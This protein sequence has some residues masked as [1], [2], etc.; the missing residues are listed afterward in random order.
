MSNTA[1][2]TRA[3]DAVI[4]L[5]PAPS[6]RGVDVL[7]VTE[8][9]FFLLAARKVVALP[10]RIWHAT[11][12]TQAADL[13]LSTPCAVALLDT[14]LI[15]EIPA[16]IARLRSQFPDLAFVVAGEA[17]AQATVAP[18]IDSGDVQSFVIKQYTGR[19]L[20]ASLQAGIDRHLDL[21]ATVTLP[22]VRS[23]WKRSPVLIGIGAGVLAAFALAV[24][25]VWLMT[26]GEKAPSATVAAN[27]LPP[28]VSA[29]K[30]SQQS[31]AVE[32]ELQ[33]AREAFEAGRYLSPGKNDDALDHYR[34]ALA[35]DPANAEAKDGL[36]R[37]TE[38]M[39]ARTE[40][41]LVEGNARQATDNLK[42][43]KA[44]EPANPRISF[45]ETQI[46]REATRT[47]TAQQ[48]AQRVEELNRRL[49]EL[50]KART[51]A[52][53]AA[54]PAPSKPAPTQQQSNAAEADRL[55]ALGYERLTQGKLIQPAEDSAQY[56]LTKLKQLQPNHPSLE[57][58]MTT[59]REQLL[60]DSEA[61]LNKV[62]PSLAHDLLDGAR[63]VGAEGKRV[64][65]LA[66]TI[67]R[68]SLQL[69]LLTNPQAL[70]PSMIVRKVE[71]NYPARARRES[72]E[73]YVDLRFTASKQ[74]EVKDVVVVGAKP[75]GY[76]EE[77]AVRAL[78]RWKLEPRKI[79]GEAYEQL[80][81]LRL[82]FKLD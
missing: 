81:S 58:A 55:L 45:L 68:A 11:S 26:G 73:G 59:L 37:I 56:Y 3:P 2:K 78:K 34:A 49:D 31:L 40:L 19:R 64:D 52:P 4:S 8:D 22:P 7:A 38:I 67:S 15:R 72:V 66:A 63:A 69:Q 53:A 41:A 14:D 35:I 44:I 18:L 1:P 24:A 27:T 10:N 5:A 20:A 16:T 30:A 65:Q 74:G 60:N 6:G 36:S 70:Q 47:A 9:D 57:P 23:G 54:A 77:E 28:A 33:M 61:A 71:P 25:A 51:A 76:F 80:F 79:E 32:Q 62:N 43:A 21:Q 12:D 13:L 42:A 48:E 50:S 17:E 39:L 75:E 82:R 46:S 29:E